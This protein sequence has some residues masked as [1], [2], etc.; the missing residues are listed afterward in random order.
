MIIPQLAST[1]DK[2]KLY[3]TGATVTRIA[4]IDLVKGEIPSQVQISGLPLTLDDSKVKARIEGEN[5]LATVTDIRIGIAIPSLPG[6]PSSNLTQE[7]QETE[8]EIKR[9]SSLLSQISQ[10]IQAIDHLQIGDRPLPEEGKAPIVSPTSA[11]LTLANFKYEQKKIKIQEQLDTQEKW[12]QAQEK[13]AELKEKQ[14]L[15]ST[16]IDFKPDDLKKTIIISLSSQCEQNNFTPQQLVI[17][18]YVPGAKWTPTYVCRLD[19]QNLTATVEI[20]AFIAQLTGEDWLG[21]KLELSTALPEQQWELPQ[22]TSLRIGRQ[23]PSP[24]IPKGWRNLP[25]NSDV[26]FEDFEQERKNLELLSTVNYQ[27]Q[28]TPFEKKIES[29]EIT[30]IGT[31]FDSSFDDNFDQELLTEPDGQW[32]EL[33][34]FLGVPD[35]FQDES[36]PT[37]GSSKPLP[38]SPPLLSQIAVGGV[39]PDSFA[40]R[41][42]KPRAMKSAPEGYSAPMP[43]MLQADIKSVSPPQKRAERRAVNINLTENINYEKQNLSYHLMRLSTVEDKN[44]R[45]KLYLEK[46]IESYLELVEFTTKINLNQQSQLT[47]KIEQVISTRKHTI[48]LP[49]KGVDVREIAGN[50]DYVY[51][52]DGRI[53][54]KS[55]GQFHSVALTKKSTNFEVLYVV[56]PRE[57]T[58]VFRIAK[59]TNPFKAPLLS[60]SCDV[61]VNGEY[62][63]TSKIKTIPAYG[64]LDLGFGIEPNIKVAR[65]TNYQE[66]KSM[67]KL[68][69]FNEFKHQITINITNLMSKKVNLEVRERIPIPD[70]NAKVNVEI[71]EVSPPWEKYEQMEGNKPIKGGHYWLRELGPKQEQTLS[72]H[73]TINTFADKEIIGGNR[74]E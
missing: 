25:F 21:V 7:I 39:P 68:G 5:Q 59:L 63:F 41:G 4:T 43:S 74:R 66:T 20:R 42:V 67:I 15:A 16:A 3:A 12:N 55:D 27:P 72:V 8:W 9:I 47:S 32:N 45:G 61:Y 38:P 26:L 60:S 58:N 11:R 71:T 53:D 13:L 52:A 40:G 31:N 44:K 2:V 62:L 51:Q 14:R 37:L 73:Y 29:R 33:E 46:Q 19:N 35:T 23:Q 1:I 49:S 64:K 22:L 17:E 50:F 28:I 18:Y 54:L 36:E 48:T 34:S 57:D 69:M 65:N 30:G 10:E 6:I 56:V 24:S 70:P